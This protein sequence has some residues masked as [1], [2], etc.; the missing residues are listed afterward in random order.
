MAEAQDNL[1]TEIAQLEARLAAKKQEAL[2]AGAELPEK[3]VFKTVV[4]EHASLEIP[5]VKIP[6]TTPVVAADPVRP[7]TQSQQQT[8][9]TLIA[10][11]FSKGIK[12][13]IAEAK[14]YN[15][16]YLIDLLHD[17]LAD[18]YYS[19]LLLARQIKPI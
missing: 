13:A 12:A 15:D 3:E 2:E 6:V 4:K 16:A 7:A 19:K 10:F 5:Q 8:I 14:K 18:E 17:R 11:S 9:N 1:N